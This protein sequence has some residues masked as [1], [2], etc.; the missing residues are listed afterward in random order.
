M[1]E[2]AENKP[3]LWGREPALILGAV[4]AAIAVGVAF[5]LP[6]TPEQ[7]GLINALAAA[8]VAVIVRQAVTPN[9]SVAERV[10]GDRVIAGPANDIVTTGALVRKTGDDL[11]LREHDGE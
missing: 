6:V 2:H 3:S 10:E 11:P 7:V 1:A 8:V 4:N 9:V 5:G